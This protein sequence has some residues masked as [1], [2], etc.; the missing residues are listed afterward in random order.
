M[1][2]DRELRTAVLNVFNS[3]LGKS[4]RDHIELDRVQRTPGF[5]HSSNTQP[6][7]V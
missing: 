6:Q 2:T 5:K 4:V 3:I 1:I 7:D